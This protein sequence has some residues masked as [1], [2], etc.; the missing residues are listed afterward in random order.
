MTS[1]WSML[2]VMCFKYWPVHLRWSSIVVQLSAICLCIST[3]GAS[4]NAYALLSG[5]SL[6]C[7]FAHGESPVW[8]RSSM[9]M[10]LVTHM[11]NS[12]GI[13]E[14]AHIILYCAC[15]LMQS[16]HAWCSLRIRHGIQCKGDTSPPLL[17]GAACQAA[18]QTHISNR[19]QPPLD[20][21]P[22]YNIRHAATHFQQ[23][24][25]CWRF[26]M[27]VRGAPALQRSYVAF[28]PKILHM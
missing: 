1:G 26:P 24:S 18:S 21:Q 23:L 14:D 28:L 5:K 22:C 13:L 11:Q 17:G 16:E 8:S 15:M 12:L 4:E 20:S 9:T 2:F 25:R 3:M 19:H 6:H 27:I 10:Q 7:S